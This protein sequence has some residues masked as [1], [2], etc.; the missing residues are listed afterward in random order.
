MT[1]FTACSNDDELTVTAPAEQA[2]P[3][4]LNLDFNLSAGGL[5]RAGRP[6]YSSQALQQVNSMTVYVFKENAG[7]YVYDNKVYTIADFDNAT[8]IG[9][10]AHSMEIETAL[11]DGSYKFLAVGLED[12]ETY[13]ALS[14]TTTTT[15]EQAAIQLTSDKKASEFF[16][17]FTNVYTVDANTQ[18][19]CVNITLTRAVAG[20]LGYFKNVPYKVLAA[21]GTMKRVAKVSIQLNQN[22]TDAALVDP[23]TEKTFGD[24]SSYTE[25]MS[26]TFDGTVQYDEAKN[27]YTCAAVTTGSA[28][29]PAKL[30]N[31]FLVGGYS[32]PCAAITGGKTMKVVLYSE[33]DE[34]LKTYP[35][36]M[37]DSSTDFGLDR[38][39][40]YG[41]GH[42]E[43]DNNTDGDLDDGDDD[44]PD[45]PNTGDPDDPVDLSKDQIIT[46]TVNANWSAIHDLELGA[47]E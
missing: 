19:L 24:G 14:F 41:I 38:N 6:L 7:S 11:T 15:L 46:I 4:T 23:A 33:D 25:L 13:E 34:A 20:V 16:A 29:N 35:V 21:D 18:S 10:E 2:H 17:G 31:S 12:D 45:D 37:D 5:K 26:I 27:I 43:A 39:G 3:V 8:A 32:L 30:E 42:K 40:F 28:G 47:A 9:D 22:A 44:D 1:T 36:Q